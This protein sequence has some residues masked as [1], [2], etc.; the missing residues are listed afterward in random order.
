MSK[1]SSNS[2]L[3][4]EQGRENTGRRK[5]IYKSVWKRPGGEL[6]PPQETGKGPP[7]LAQNPSKNQKIQPR[8]HKKYRGETKKF[9]TLGEKW[10]REGAGGCCS[11]SYMDISW[12]E[13]EAPLT[14]YLASGVK[15]EE[16]KAT[17]VTMAGNSTGSSRW[18]MKKEQK[19]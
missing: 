15:S 13:Q 5:Q 18:V 7:N 8:T 17:W 9:K 11:C 12:T 1:S 4:E 16:G 2:R 14:V 6:K 3:K 19:P 10:G